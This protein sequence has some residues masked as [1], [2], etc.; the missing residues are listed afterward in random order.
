M[1]RLC[2]F[3]ITLVIL[4]VSPCH[5]EESLADHLLVVYNRNTSAGKHLA[6]FY[7]KRRG[8]PEERVLGIDCSKN[9][10]ISRGE[11]EKTIRR[12]IDKYL[13]SKGWI[14]RQE[15][16]VMLGNR[17][18]KTDAAIE[19]DI[20]AIVLIHGIPLR[21]A[22]TPRTKPKE[23]QP[24]PKSYSTQR[25]EAAIDSELSLLPLSKVPI[26]GT[27]PNPYAVN[28]VH[29]PRRFGAR[30]ALRQ[31]LVTRLDAASSS[32][33]MRMI[34]DSVTAER[35]RLAGW[36]VI[37]QRGIT[38]PKNGYAIGDQ[39]LGQTAAALFRAGWPVSIDQ[40][41]KVLP[42]TATLAD[43]AI[44]AGWY[45]GASKGPFFVPPKR[46]VSGAIA[47][48]LHSF[49][50]SSL[51]SVE[52]KH[53]AWVA[54]LI[55]AGA[56]ASMGCVYEPYLGFT[57]HVGIFTERLLKGMTFAEAAYASQPVLS[58]MTTVVG[59]PLYRPFAVPLE[60]ALANAKREGLA[61]EPFLAL[62]R[63]RLALSADG[64]G[65]N[66]P[67]LQLMVED[68]GNTPLALESMGDLL[69]DNAKKNPEILK[70]AGKAYSEAMRSATQAITVIRNGKKVRTMLTK[71]N[72]PTEAEAVITE[73]RK[74]YP[75]LAASCGLN[76]SK[77]KAP[78]A[79]VP[80]LPTGVE[81][82]RQVQ[83]ARPAP[84]PEK[85]KSKKDIDKYLKSLIPQPPKP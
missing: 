76:P 28:T 68:A 11:Y 56:A 83:P 43:V 75:K 23:G 31:V 85:L 12:P 51:R 21:I 48:H 42:P 19:N 20:W 32:D 16:N 61:N 52:G 44:Y 38:D 70:A 57:P 78:P 73:L 53:R 5:A 29:S 49:S 14:R 26:A 46:F 22:N 81:Q 72:R 36:G 47:Y 6:E 74:R 55:R 60:K 10:T 39:W 58:W 69:A 82:T 30:D 40:S 27:L 24:W 4:A 66:Y 71:L 84:A 59:D 41:P 1:Q 13:S 63:A 33:V 34:Q 2:L 25:D 37:D 77:P 8:I 62:E 45:T 9:E 15:R 17:K 3:S 67:R 64:S 50:A 80:P 7:A 79:P 35:Q 18:I 65:V 54:P